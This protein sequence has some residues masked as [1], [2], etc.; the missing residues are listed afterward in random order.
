MTLLRLQQCIGQEFGVSGN[1]GV[2]DLAYTLTTAY[3]EITYV[4][5]RLLQVFHTI[6][7]AL[8]AQPIES[9]VDGKIGGKLMPEAPV[10]TLKLRGG[11]WLRFF[12]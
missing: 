5:C 6:D 8:D 1:E 4:I 10:I 11:L 7:P 2:R 3:L 9:W 12:G